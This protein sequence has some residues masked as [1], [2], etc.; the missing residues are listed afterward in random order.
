M[1]KFHLEREPAWYDHFS[2]PGLDNRSYHSD[3]D[4]G[5]MIG[6]LNES[7]RSHANLGP[8]VDPAPIRRE[9]PRPVIRGQVRPSPVREVTPD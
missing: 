1:L 6:L 5:H 7:D 4:G 9:R 8:N 2:T 3:S